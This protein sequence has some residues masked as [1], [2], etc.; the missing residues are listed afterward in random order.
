V[1]AQQPAAWGVRAEPPKGVE[2]TRT[3]VLNVGENGSGIG[4]GGQPPRRVSGRAA[5]RQRARRCSRMRTPAS[6]ADAQGRSHRVAR[7][8]GVARGRRSRQ[9]RARRSLRRAWRAAPA[10]GEYDGAGTTVR[11]QHAAAANRQAAVSNANRRAKR[12]AERAQ[13]TEARGIPA[14]RA[15]TAQRARQGSPVAKRRARI[16]LMDRRE[17]QE[18]GQ[19]RQKEVQVEKR[20]RRAEKHGSGEAAAERGAEGDGLREGEPVRRRERN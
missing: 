1:T 18:R 12:S 10:Q 14:R 6:Q 16:H 15:E 4:T 13:R 7:R 17:Q 2:K 20:Q 5:T 19:H 9:G 3:R 8:R 11:A